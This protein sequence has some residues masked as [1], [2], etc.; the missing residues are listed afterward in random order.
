MKYIK[1]IFC[2]LTL[3]LVLSPAMA[4][5]QDKKGID[6]KGILMG[7]IKDSY[8]WHITDFM[9]KHIILYL[10]VIVKSSTGW[11]VFCSDEFAHEPNEQGDRPGPYGLYI[12][13]NK[14][15]ENKIC[16]KVSG[17]EVRPFDISITK[18]AVILF[19]NA[20][21]LLLCILIPSR[22]WYLIVYSFFYLCNIMD[23]I[24]LF[25]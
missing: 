11:H 24:L 18:T 17:K 21:V 22:W 14:E 5:N 7:H 8:E 13:N 3:F 20:I 23:Y 19:I 1:H 12:A 4:A 6:L 25:M 9:G 16:E 10:P 15:H 2:L